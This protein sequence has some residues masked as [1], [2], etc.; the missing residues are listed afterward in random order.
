MGLSASDVKWL[1]EKLRKLD[2]LSYHSEE[3][4]TKLVLSI[5]KASFP[6]KTILRQ[7][8]KGEAL[9]LIRRGKAAV[10]AETP[11]GRRR[12]AEL[13]EGE[14]FGEVSILTGDICNASVAAE[15]EAELFAL[16]PDEVREVVKAKPVLAEKRADAISK[17]NGVRALGLAPA[18]VSSSRLLAALNPFGLRMTF[19][20]KL[21]LS[22]IF[23]ILPLAYV[24]GVGESNPYFIYTISTL[25]IFTL[26][27]T[28]AGA[29]KVDGIVK[30]SETRAVRSE[31]ELQAF[32]ERVL[33]GIFSVDTGGTVRDI[34][35]AMA[36]FLRHDPDFLKGRCL[37][38]HLKCPQ[39]VPDE[40]FLPKGQVRCTLVMTGKLK[41]G[42][43]AELL[44]DLYAQRSGG[45]FNGFRGCARPVESLGF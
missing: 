6:R 9:Y 44:V 37:W 38:E 12:L 20:A 34:N 18:A 15:G 41:S 2:F 25:I 3:E 36:Q 31:V 19:K 45:V 11:Q 28:L 1:F 32:K 5:K 13:A 43:T 30:N 22:F 29:V 14:N 8:Q 10:W 17:R 16:P 26:I 27:G 21:F 35:T 4:L 39:G 24:F 23:S 40:S 7:G 33:D 42:G